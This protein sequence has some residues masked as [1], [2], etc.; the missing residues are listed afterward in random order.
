MS[1]TAVGRALW[2]LLYTGKP[3]RE[4][5]VSREGIELRASERAYRWIRSRIVSGDHPVGGRLKEEELSEAIG[6]SRTPVREALQ[7]LAAEGI[8]EFV[9]HRGAYVATWS[10]TDIEEIFDLRARLESYGARRAANGVSHE[11]IVRLRSLANQMD[12]AAREGSANAADLVAELNNEFHQIIVEAAHSDR[13]A[14]LV[15]GLIQVA[16]V[17]RTFRRYSPRH[18]ARSLAHHHEL[19]DA[20]EA[21]DPEW[22]ESVMHSHVRAALAA[23]LDSERTVGELDHG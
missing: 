23:L 14:P 21:R 3:S 2:H 16:L 11:E 20:L 12:A 4:G 1:A 5:F 17:H 15:T 10:A 7:K 6:V 22:A 19:V 18:L 8:V 9:P 13:L